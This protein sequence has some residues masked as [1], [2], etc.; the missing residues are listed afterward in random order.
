MC[1]NPN[2]LFFTWI[3]KTLG[4]CS[5]AIT[6]PKW[7]PSKWPGNSCSCH[8]S[9]LLLLNCCWPDGLQ[10]H[11]VLSLLPRTWG[12][13][14]QDY[15]ILCEVGHLHLPAQGTKPGIRNA[16]TDAMISNWTMI[17]PFLLWQ[18][19]TLWEYIHILKDQTGFLTSLIDVGFSTTEWGGKGNIMN[20][21][22]GVEE[23][24]SSVS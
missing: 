9:R 7:Q 23:L 1:N 16:S 21:V 17:K 24:L 4:H 6:W 13:R 3:L 12:W 5:S 19:A 10:H 8:K 14:Q 2:K 22:A 18:K 20:C 11:Y 15:K